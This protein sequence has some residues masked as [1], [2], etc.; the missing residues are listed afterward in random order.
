MPRLRF[1]DFR[2]SRAP[3][4]LGL[5]N[6]D[7]LSLANYVNSAQRRLIFAREGS[8]EGW[9]GTFAEVAFT[10][11]SRSNPYITC[12]RA[13]ARL[14]KIAVCNQPIP[15]QNQFY[16]YRDFG[17]GRMPKL[18]RGAGWC[19]FTRQMFTR[20][21]VVTFS[22][23]TVR[24]CIIRVRAAD[25]ADTAG[26]KRVVVQGQDQNN[27]VVYTQDVEQQV[28]GELITLA[29]PFADST[30]QFNILSGFQ[31]DETAGNVS[32]YQVDPTTGD[33]RLLL[34]MEPSEKVAGYRRYF[35]NHLPANCCN[36]NGPE[37]NLTITAIAKLEIIPVVVDTDYLLLQNLEALIEECIAVRMSEMDSLTA[38]QL[39]GTHHQNAIRM[40]ISECTHYLG[41]L[42]PAVQFAPFGSAK[43]ERLNVGMV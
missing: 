28:E 22:D 20:N 19:D 16:E 14:E 1:L 2:T 3:Q 35:L 11:V 38:Q 32:F 9:W 5:C 39:A 30:Y 31:K 12:P 8:E 10:T 6:D 42:D 23:Q 29:S 17:N 40:L 43:L 24:P 34:T 15:I 33:E 21:N 27:M 13:I 37:E 36:T 26:T 25:T 18:C 41:K 7:R 4:V